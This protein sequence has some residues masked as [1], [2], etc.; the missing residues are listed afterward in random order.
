MVSMVASANLAIAYSLPHFFS[1]QQKAMRGPSTMAFKQSFLK[2]LL[3]SLQSSSKAMTLH[4]R[5]HAIKSSADIAMA[6]ARGIAGGTRWPQAILASSSSSSSTIPCKMQGKVKRC[7]SI[8]RRCCNKRRRD[9]CSSTSFF[10]RTALS[11]SSEVARR[12]VKERTK[13]LRRMIPGGELLDEISLLHEAMDYVVH[14]HA[15]VDVLRR[16]SKAMRR[17]SNASSSGGFAQLKEET[18][19]ISGETDHPCSPVL[20]NPCLTR[21]V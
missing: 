5:K 21:T 7:K 2:N 10:A 11:S 3:L 8:V 16:V 17:R 4:E 14:L 13:V 9:G 15:Q 20:S 1:P 6:T 19:Q 18:V 12:L